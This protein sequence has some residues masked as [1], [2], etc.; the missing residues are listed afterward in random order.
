[1]S[2]TTAAEMAVVQYG[3]TAEMTA[4]SG[5][6]LGHT[7]GI[8]VQLSPHLD[9]EVCGDSQVSQIVHSCSQDGAEQKEVA[10]GD[11][12]C[13]AV[14]HAPRRHN[15]VQAKDDRRSMRGVVIG[16]RPVPVRQE[17]TSSCWMWLAGRQ[18]V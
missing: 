1:M 4:S 16:A 12:A 5:K 3:S 18:Q 6:P 8:R 10:R 13:Q 7:Q 15:L 2:Y 11:G 17:P 9:Q 14:C